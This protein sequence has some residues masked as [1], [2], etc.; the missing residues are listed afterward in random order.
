M[1]KVMSL[2]ILTLLIGSFAASSSIQAAP[3]TP[4]APRA[5][6]GGVVALTF[7]D[8]PTPET[9]AVL[10]ALKL[11]GLKGTFFLIGLNVEAY[12]DIAKRIVSEGHHVGNHSWDHPRLDDSDR[13]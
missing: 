13:G 2:L 6:A 5:C 3:Q 9:N 8:G 7:D 10:D 4:A 1:R 11:Y 12:P